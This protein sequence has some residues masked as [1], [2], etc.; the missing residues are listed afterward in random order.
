M[1]AMQL[2]AYDFLTK[3]LDMDQALATVTRALRHI[4]LQREWSVS[5]HSDL[6]IPRSR[7][8]N[9]IKAGHDSS[10]TRRHGSKFSRV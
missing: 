6:K 9:Q 10:G 7:L 1:Q 3:P 2:G 5:G 4:E 8:P